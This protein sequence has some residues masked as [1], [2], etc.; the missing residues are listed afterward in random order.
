MS[1][2]SPSPVSTR[3]VV[4]VVTFAALIAVLGLLPPL[5]VPVIPVP[6]TA[7]TLGVMLAGAVLGPRRGALAVVLFLLIV[8]LGFPF[9]SGGRG[10]LGVFA[11]PGGG[12]LIGWIAGAAVTGALCPRRS[13]IGIARGLLA[14]I[15]GGIGAVYLIGV[16][17][18][19]AV[20]DFKLI[21]AAIASAAF[22]PGDI[23]KAVIAAAAAQTV[24][25]AYPEVPA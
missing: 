19:A 8:G 15:A 16:P 23:A 18:M 3:A 7:Q 6:V 22:L 21:Q 24:R 4:H 20:G 17:W 10:G 5:P 25:R 1:A 9:L 2:A 13:E 11:A 12:F 14:C